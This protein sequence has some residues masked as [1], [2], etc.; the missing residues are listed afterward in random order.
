[1][2]RAKQN[3]N[4][5]PSKDNRSIAMEENKRIRRDHRGSADVADFGSI[6]ASLLVRAIS[7]VSSRG[8]AIQLGYTR[9]GGAYRFRIVG[10][11]EPYDEYVRPSEDVEEYLNGL[12][13]D[14]AK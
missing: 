2:T 4:P 6:E 1:M 7:A 11:G 10:D 5:P 14:F 3:Q 8:C 12:I 13:L 9:D